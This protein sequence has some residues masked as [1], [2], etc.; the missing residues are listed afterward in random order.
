MPYSEKVISD[1][2][3]VVCQV[4]EVQVLGFQGFDVPCNFCLLC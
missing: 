2:D 4:F 1:S 3:Y